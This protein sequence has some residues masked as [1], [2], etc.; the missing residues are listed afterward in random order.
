MPYRENNTPDSML[1][2]PDAVKE[3]ASLKL[4]KSIDEKLDLL[5]KEVNKFKSKK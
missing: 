5:L 1:N 2:E 4:L 3:W